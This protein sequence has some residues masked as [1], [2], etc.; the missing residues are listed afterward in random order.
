VRQRLL[1]PSDRGVGILRSAGSD[2]GKAAHHVI[3]QQAMGLIS[4]PESFRT[5][6]G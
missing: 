3:E 1:Q 2:V 4:Q 6:P 5:A